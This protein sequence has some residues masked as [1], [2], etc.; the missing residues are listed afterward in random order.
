MSLLSM[1]AVLAYVTVILGHVTG[2]EIASATFQRRTFEYFQ[3]PFIELQISGISRTDSTGVLED[4]LIDEKIISVAKTKTPPD[5]SIRWDLVE[6]HRFGVIF[7]RG[8]AEI[9]CHYLDAED[10]DE[11]NV[12]VEWSKDNPKLAKV[13]WPAVVTVAQQELYIFVPELLELAGN[14]TD[15]DAL[16]TQLAELQSRQ[17]L[18]VAT[19]LQQLAR[20][21]LAVELFSHSLDRSPG[22]IDAL[23]RRA[24]SLAALGKTEK[25]EADLAQVRELQRF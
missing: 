10:A 22:D 17:Y 7:S 20:H 25:A 18:R 9:L 12:W 4:H 13:I 11:N 1:L 2:E 6:A 19:T 15:P 3:V 5:E 23:Q 8:E 16:K 21:E 14:A 24:V